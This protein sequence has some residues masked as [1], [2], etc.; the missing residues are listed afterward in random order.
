M[1]TKY[2]VESS[3]R[4]LARNARTKV[5]GERFLISGVTHNIDPNAKLEHQKPRNNNPARK[6]E[7]RPETTTA[8]LAHATQAQLSCNNEPS[9]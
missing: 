6:R 9:G 8:T 2:R 3:Q 4:T 1:R 7:N 5:S